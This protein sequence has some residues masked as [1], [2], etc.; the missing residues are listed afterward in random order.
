MYPVP[1]SRPFCPSILIIVNFDLW[2]QP[3]ALKLL[4]ALRRH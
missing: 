1:A 3:K 2:A 4:N